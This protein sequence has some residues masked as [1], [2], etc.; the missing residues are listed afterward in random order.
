[1]NMKESNSMGMKE[2][3]TG[4][5]VPRKALHPPLHVRARKAAMKLPGADLLTTYV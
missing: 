3:H 4:V 1:M 5:V 2:M